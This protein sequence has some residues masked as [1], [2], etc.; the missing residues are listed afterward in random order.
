MMII[1]KISLSNFCICNIVP[2]TI[3]TMLYINIP[4]TYNCVYLLIT[5]LDLSLFKAKNNYPFILKITNSNSVQI[6][7]EDFFPHITSGLTVMFWPSCARTILRVIRMN[8]VNPLFVSWWGWVSP[9]CN[10]TLE[11]P[12][13]GEAW[14]VY[15]SPTS[16]SVISHCSLKWAMGA[17]CTSWR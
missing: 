5:S 4:T 11:L 15:L 1:L 2:L 14:C 10:G 16:G 7:K 3:V 17:V 8:T 13:S 9:S 12:H 6:L